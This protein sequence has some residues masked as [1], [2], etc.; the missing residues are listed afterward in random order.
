MER[1][2]VPLL[3]I[4]ADV[5]SVSRNFVLVG[6]RRQRE[7]QGRKVAGLDAASSSTNHCHTYTPYSGL[8][9]A[10]ERRIR[11]TTPLVLPYT[12]ALWWVRGQQGDRRLQ[13]EQLGAGGCQPL[14]TI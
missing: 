4:F 9:S 12:R 13:P 5:L 6:A 7:R 3:K 14:T 8:V 11:D 1:C 2:E 10:P